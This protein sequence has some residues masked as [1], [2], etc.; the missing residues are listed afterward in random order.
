MLTVKDVATLLLVTTKTVRRMVEKQEFPEPIRVGKSDRWTLGD[1]RR[2]QLEQ[3]IRG[4]KGITEAA[5]R[6]QSGTSE[7]PPPDSSGKAEKRR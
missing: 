5:Y 3:R 7:I 6:G 4:S 1:V 2:W